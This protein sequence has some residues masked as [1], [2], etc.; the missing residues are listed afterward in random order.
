MSDEEIRGASGRFDP[1][2]ASSV[3]ITIFR[4]F[5]VEFRFFWKEKSDGKHFGHGGNIDRISQG[6]KI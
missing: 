1:S 4:Q 5:S 3:T 6:L 2:T